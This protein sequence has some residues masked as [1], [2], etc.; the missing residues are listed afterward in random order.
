MK[1]A[2]PALGEGEEPE[3]PEGHMEEA[4]HLFSTL[5]RLVRP[6]AVVGIMVFPPYVLG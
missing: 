4:T 3:E 1:Q 2:E 5:A 6:V